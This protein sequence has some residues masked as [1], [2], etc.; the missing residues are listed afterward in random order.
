MLIW[1]KGIGLVLFLDWTCV[2]QTSV[3]RKPIGIYDSRLRQ[4]V[5]LL[6]LIHELSDLYVR[7]TSS[8]HMQIDMTRPY[9]CTW[10]I[11]TTH[12]EFDTSYHKSYKIKS[13]IN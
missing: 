6:W 10:F 5:V 12:L 8:R 4:F 9:I 7:D 3:G 1:V 11:N 13:R 2:C